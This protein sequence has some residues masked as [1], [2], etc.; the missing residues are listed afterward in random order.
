MSFIYFTNRLF[1]VTNVQAFIYFQTHSGTRIG[2]YN[3]KFVVRPW[4]TFL[5]PVFDAISGHRAS[6]RVPSSE[7]VEI[8]L[9]PGLLG[10]SMLCT[11]P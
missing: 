2:L 3:L 11:L 5:C 6:V 10:F 1:G 4:C 7:Y 8:E 9:F